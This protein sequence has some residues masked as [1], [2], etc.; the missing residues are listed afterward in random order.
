MYIYQR[1]VTAR[2]DNAA[3]RSDRVG[4]RPYRVR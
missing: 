1:P 2:A 4:R 3:G